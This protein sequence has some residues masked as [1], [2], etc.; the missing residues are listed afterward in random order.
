MK[1][2]FILIGVCAVILTLSGCGLVRQQQ[3]AKAKEEFKADE[4]ACEQGELTRANAIERRDCINAAIVKHSEEINYPHMDLV[5]QLNAVNEKAAVLYSEGKIT[6]DE[7]KVAVMQNAADA[8]KEEKAAA[9]VQAQSD[10]RLNANIANWAYQQQ[11]LMQANQPSSNRIICNNNPMASGT[12]PN[13][14]ICQSY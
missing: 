5:L 11:T 6:K 14:T 3:M 1:N 9:A 4:T 10:A 8:A 12:M 2:R 13:P 7:Y